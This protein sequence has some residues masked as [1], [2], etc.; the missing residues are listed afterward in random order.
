MV[1]HFVILSI[2]SKIENSESANFFFFYIYILIIN[3]FY[4]ISGQYIK[5]ALLGQLTLEKIKILI[6]SM[7]N[8]NC[9][10]QYMDSI[11][12]PIQNDA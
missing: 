4:D 8:M 7:V 10:S 11:W 9:I 2:I 1:T 3:L 5:Y 12:L 6:H